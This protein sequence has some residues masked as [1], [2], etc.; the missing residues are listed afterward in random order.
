MVLKA[1]AGLKGDKPDWSL[2]SGTHFKH[3]LRLCLD[4]WWNSMNFS[5]KFTWSQSNSRTG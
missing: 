5:S 2:T 3:S 1:R 4:L